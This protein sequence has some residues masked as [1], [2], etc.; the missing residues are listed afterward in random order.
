MTDHDDFQDAASV[1]IVTHGYRVRCTE[2][3]CGNLARTI[4]RYTDAGGRPLSNLERCNRH[5]A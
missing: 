5:A 2:P 3:E 4:L 1:T